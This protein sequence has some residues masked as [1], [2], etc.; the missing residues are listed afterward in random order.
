MVFRKQWLEYVRPNNYWLF[1]HTASSNLFSGMDKSVIC[2]TVG[3]ADN[4]ASPS[5]KISYCTLC[6][7][8]TKLL[9]SLLNN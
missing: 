7:E 8:I 9:Y 2:P 5:Q 1:P 6:W 4:C 3:R